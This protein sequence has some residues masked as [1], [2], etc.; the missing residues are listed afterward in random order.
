MFSEPTTAMSW[1]NP[2][3]SADRS[4]APDASNPAPS[5]DGPAQFADRLGR[6]E[7]ILRQSPPGEPAKE[8]AALGV[9]VAALQELVQRGFE[10]LAELLAPRGAE[11]A[12]DVAAGST[13]A[14]GHDA[15]AP[16]AV[17]TA[18]ASGAG[19]AAWERAI[20][21]DALADDEALAFTRRRF[22]Q[23]VLGGRPAACGLAG[24]LLAFRAAAPERLPQLLKDI[25]EA[26]YRWQPKRMAES[27]ALEEALVGW[28][29]RR[30]ELADLSNTI[31]LVHPGQRF[32]AARHNAASR[33]VEVVEVQGWVVLREGGKVYTKASVAVR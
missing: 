15:T 31:E 21:G 7:E 14:A 24:S 8:T 27:S 26:Y 10:H 19:L 30:C 18:P 23:E 32:D 11:P 12:D 13:V 4:P 22:V 1:S 20:L 2:P 5:P 16:A 33:G 25:G 29:Q 17:D 9:A 28:L 3:E 6:I